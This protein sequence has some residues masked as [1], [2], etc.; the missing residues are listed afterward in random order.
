L[1]SRERGLESVTQALLDVVPGG[2]LARGW[3]AVRRLRTLVEPSDAFPNREARGRLANSKREVARVAAA[4]VVAVEC[5]RRTNP[6]ARVAA[7]VVVVAV[8]CLRRTNPFARVAAVAPGSPHKDRNSRPAEPDALVVEGVGDHK[9]Q[10]LP[11]TRAFARADVVVREVVRMGIASAV[12]VVFLE[13]A[14]QMIARA[15]DCK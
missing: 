15:I 9:V 6:F 4:V 10:R 3:P 12:Q 8:E 2:R 7:A 5:L 11:R 1:Q 13:F 14:P